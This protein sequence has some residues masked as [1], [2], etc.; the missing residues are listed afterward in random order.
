MSTSHP[1]RSFSRLVQEEWTAE[2]TIAAWRRWHEKMGPHLGTLT[3][4]LLDA[5]KRLRVARCWTLPGVQAIRLP[6]SHP[7]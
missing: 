3:R 7:W 4:S 5:A 6:P 1:D 2:S